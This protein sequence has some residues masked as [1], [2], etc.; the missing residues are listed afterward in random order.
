MS[1]IIL[2]DQDYLAS[3]VT[4]MTRLGVRFTAGLEVDEL[5]GMERTYALQFPP[6][7]GALLQYAVPVGDKFP[8]WRGPKREVEKLLSWPLDGLL[9]DV[10]RNSFWASSWGPRPT[11]LS[12]ALTMVREAFMGAPKLV[13]VYMHRYMPSEPAGVSNPVL[14]VYQSDIIR[15]AN[16][17]PSYLWKEFAVPLPLK[18]TTTPI[19]VRF[20]D[21]LIRLNEE[22]GDV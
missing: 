20:W 3:V 13:P 18:A 11:E 17:L 14:S 5:V 15:Y 8:D 22:R 12:E 2:P 19:E 6:D 9:F 16:D 21:E 7:L 4:S 1:S 10:E